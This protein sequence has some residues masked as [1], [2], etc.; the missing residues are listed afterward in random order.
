MDQT[1]AVPEDKT[2]G[3]MSLIEHL[4]EL[5]A[6]LLKMLLAFL[7][8]SAVSWFFYNRILDIL[9]RPLTRL[10][11]ADKIISGGQLIFTAPQEAFF[12]RLKVVAFAGF[13]F[14][15]PVILWQL[16]RFVTPGLY[17]NEKKWA[18]AFAVSSIGLFAGGVAFAF[19]LLPQALRVLL[20]FAGEHIVLLPRASEYLSFV[21]LLIVAF[22][23]AFE[24]PLVLLSLTLA[25]V[26]STRTLRR[27]RRVAWLVILILA[28]VVTPTQ[29][30]Y[31]LML[32]AVP[33]ALLYEATILVARLFKR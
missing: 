11:E 2:S 27:G 5:R 20:G 23:A 26:L 22:G 30:P 14:S 13:V 17:A 6:R 16:W 21:M 32:M 29:D 24:L 15:L 18:L 8:A 9:V 25:R 3:G 19:A 4:E 28:A 31:T 12:V 7:G 1:E 10:P 33:L